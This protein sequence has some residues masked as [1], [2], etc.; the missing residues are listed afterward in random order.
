MLHSVPYR[1]YVRSRTTRDSKIRNVTT[2]RLVVGGG[3]WI[4]LT[5]VYYP[6]TEGPTGQDE[7]RFSIVTY[8]SEINMHAR[9][10]HGKNKPRLLD[11]VRNAIRVRHMA[12]STEKVYV[13]WTRDK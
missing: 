5:G 8:N 13:D 3:K 9:N 12:R 6:N 7:W 1:G 11:Q 10:H 4:A 2:R